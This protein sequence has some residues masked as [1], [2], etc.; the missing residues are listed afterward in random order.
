MLEASGLCAGYGSREV[1]RGASLQVEAGETVAIIGPNG[2][3]KSTLL[4]AIAGFVPLRGGSI[5]LTGELVGRLPPW[6]M[7]RKGV[8]LLLQGGQVFPPMTVADAIGLALSAGP[9]EK[10]PRCVVPL[11]DSLAALSTRRCGVLSA[12]ERQ[13]LS[14]AVVLLQHPQYLLL[15][16]PSANLA[17]GPAREIAAAIRCYADASRCCVLLVEQNVRFAFELSSR[18]YSMTAGELVEVPLRGG[19]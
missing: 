18:A 2:S 16:E 14:V 9:M 6:V 12:G 4:R 3:G 15:D 7:H 17:A 11:L 19:K 1:L 10:P 13:L 8:V 5:S